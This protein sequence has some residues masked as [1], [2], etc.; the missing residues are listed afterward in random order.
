M[1]NKIQVKRYSPKEEFLNILTH[2]GGA[3]AAVL[4]LISMLNKSTDS[5]SYWSAIIFGMSLVVLYLA[6]TLY[7]SAKSD[8][9]RLRLRI[10]DHSAIFI[11]IAGTY[12]PY[13]L[14]VLNG[15]TGNILLLIIWSLA[16]LGIISKLFFT[17]KYQR[18]STIMYVLMGWVAV[19]FVNPLIENF[20][21]EGL[22]WLLAGGIFYTVGAI[23][24]A[25]KSIPFNHAIFH[26]FVLAGSFTHFWS[27]YIY[28]L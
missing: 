12:T 8:T 20:S 5:L 21:T 23:L 26:V 2:A 14:V 9:W 15:K 13:A 7:H 11:L 24:Y 1:A 4:A 19:G 25:I 3:L 10:A 17:G 6:S 18:L 28:V 27:V 16:I 22:L